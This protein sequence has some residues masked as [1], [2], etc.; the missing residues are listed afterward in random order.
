MMYDVPSPTIQNEC[1]IALFYA[2]ILE[3][4]ASR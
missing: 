4:I 1:D 2:S 3:P